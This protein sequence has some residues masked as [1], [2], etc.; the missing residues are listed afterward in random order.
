M[1]NSA[2]QSDADKFFSS[3]IQSSMVASMEKDLTP[4]ETA[5][6]FMQNVVAKTRQL[7]K[8]TQHHQDYNRFTSA[9]RRQAG[10]YNH[11]LSN[12]HLIGTTQQISGIGKEDVVIQP[13]RLPFF[14]AEKRRNELKRLVQL[15]RN[16]VAPGCSIVLD[17]FDDYIYACF[18][19]CLL[20]RKL[21]FANAKNH[22][23]KQKQI[24][25]AIGAEIQCL[26]GVLVI[27]EQSGNSWRSPLGTVYE[28]CSPPILQEIFMKTFDAIIPN[29]DILNLQKIETGK[30]FINAIN[31]LR[32][33][34]CQEMQTLLAPLDPDPDLSCHFQRLSMRLSRLRQTVDDLDTSLPS[35]INLLKKNREYK[36]L[37]AQDK[38]TILEFCNA[39]EKGISEIVHGK[40]V[41]LEK[42]RELFLL[43]N[44][45]KL[46][47]SDLDK[48]TGRDLLN[49]VGGDSITL[50]GKSNPTQE[51]QELAVIVRLC[52][53]YVSTWHSI[54]DEGQLII[55]SKLIKTSQL[56]LV[57]MDECITDILKVIESLKNIPYQSIEAQIEAFEKQQLMANDLSIFIEIKNI[58]NKS[59]KL[60]YDRYI[61]TYVK[62]F[63]TRLSRCQKPNSRTIERALTMR[64]IL[65][66]CSFTLS[67]QNK[68][69]NENLT[70]FKN[71]FAFDS[72]ELEELYNQIINVNEIQGQ[73]L[74]AT[75]R[76]IETLLGRCFDRADIE[77]ALAE[78]LA[79][80][81]QMESKAEA[82][83]AFA[84]L[85]EQESKKKKK[86]TK[87][88]EIPT[89]SSIQE[90]HSGSSNLPPENSGPNN[91]SA[92]APLDIVVPNSS[93]T[94]EI[95]IE[96]IRKTLS[97]VKKLPI[98]GPEADY[99]AA[100][101]YA[102]LRNLK[103]FLLQLE[104]TINDP[105]FTRN[106]ILGETDT[107]RRS[108]EAALAITLGHYP[109]VD[110]NEKSSLHQSLKWGHQLHLFIKCI[111]QKDKV[112]PNNV[113]QVIYALRSIPNSLSQ[114][115]NFVNYPHSSL[116]RNPQDNILTKY[117]RAV[118]KESNA[119]KPSQK[120]QETLLK[121]HQ[122][123][124][125][126]ALFFISELLQAIAN[127]NYEFDCY[128]L[129][130]DPLEAFDVDMSEEF[131]IQNDE[132]LSKDQEIEIAKRLI[133][134]FQDSSEKDVAIRPIRTR[135]EALAA[136]DEALI[137][138]RIRMISPSEGR[139]Q[140][141]KRVVERNKALK[142]V[143]HYLQWISE[144]LA[145]RQMHLYDTCCEALRLLR[146]THKE[147]SIGVL[148]HGSYYYDGL[149]VVDAENLRRL[150][151]PCFLNK[152]LRSH[153]SCASRLPSLNE[154]RFVWMH[155]AHQILSYPTPVEKKKYG[156]D[157]EELLDLVEKVRKLSR[158]MKKIQ[159]NFTLML[160]GKFELT[161]E[162]NQE[163]INEVISKEEKEKIFPA[164][165]ALLQ[166]LRYGMPLPR[167]ILS[168]AS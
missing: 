163:R 115:N 96:N 102:A 21:D 46:D 148:Y 68:I 35:E 155:H 142:N 5:T 57:E 10:K 76:N 51:E 90:Q 133:K 23:I 64:D 87:K 66:L 137:W 60:F 127:P 113:R 114:A 162:E 117:L 69:V 154:S 39:V 55:L 72:K 25:L 168:S 31:L 140:T 134:D 28:N 3:V 149:H 75:T 122:A 32:D 29:L 146:R 1:Q 158:Q 11:I 123:R 27:F 125:R 59:F 151:N 138:I 15:S 34:V 94:P 24:F 71:I 58:W 62:L 111:L 33:V 164:L 53:A 126:D 97:E 124:V 100:W 17:L 30:K 65:N 70:S 116:E 165:M 161:A 74:Q 120:L 112:I 167:T 109:A 83:T 150:N 143:I 50:I 47:Q 159:G 141:Q 61:D 6:L 81:Q 108:L 19:E 8:I 118:N 106:R 13:Y 43:F 130:S 99:R 98:E 54:V 22:S 45:F 2:V 52:N 4:M 128:T 157:A 166:I 63:K 131:S 41:S 73:A 18:R 103:D 36:D 107:I 129:P 56:S 79:K 119:A 84:S 7:E 9:R 135:K 89:H 77:A 16:E 48:N 136:I 105:Q 26:I 20:D 37:F 44:Q 139:I 78:E 14:D 86:K 92:P 156:F 42:W 40:S 91:I 93:N 12:G 110:E 144:K 153:S 82:E 160:P 104:E 85:I 49:K 101:C 132:S 147:L 38:K 152:I 145:S 67:N 121:T 88:D 80:T 95:I